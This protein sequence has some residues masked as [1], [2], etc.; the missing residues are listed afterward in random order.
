MTIM[1]IVGMCRSEV[2]VGQG[3]WVGVGGAINPHVFCIVR[4]L[5]M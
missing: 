4:S 2:I 5:L 3:G 1:M